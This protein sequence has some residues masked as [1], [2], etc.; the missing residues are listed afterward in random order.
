MSDMFDIAIL[1]AGLAAGGALMP[2]VVF[3]RCG[4]DI[5]LA[6]LPGGKPLDD[7]SAY[8]DKI[9]DILLRN[10]QR[11]NNEELNAFGRALFDYVVRDGVREI[12][13]E[14]SDDAPVRIHILTNRADLQSLP[15]EYLLF[16]KQPSAPWR[17]RT[18]VRILAS[19]GQKPPE[20][21]ELAAGGAKLKILFVYADPPTK[22]NVPWQE[23]LKG[24]ELKL[25]AQMPR[26]GFELT[27]VEGRP[28]RL[29]K[30][31]RDNSFDIFHFVGH[32]DIDPVTKKGHL[33]LLDGANDKSLKIES[34]DLAA[35]LGDHGIRLAVMSACNTSAGN[36]AAPFG[37]VA[38]ALLR[39]RIPAVVAN[40][41]PVPISSVATFV[42]RLYEV[43]LATGDI[44]EAFGEGRW[45]LWEEMKLTQGARFE[46]GIPTLYRH[47]AA[48]QIFRPPSPS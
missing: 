24:I 27:L 26:D 2:A 42:G 7:L 47:V 19:V 10:K 6:T 40:H 4:S 9:H 33:L 44:D 21:R 34:E 38:E 20:P 37:I 46:W 29:F 13:D 36:A 41:L 23:V 32:G 48:A 30:A 45:R 35:T 3:A 8:R 5:A 16:P 31:L 39:A 28:E 15:W 12:Y 25:V 1:D 11:P 43:L 22:G 18:V 14:L 17:K